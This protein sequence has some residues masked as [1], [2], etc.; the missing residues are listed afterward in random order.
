[1][2]HEFFTPWRETQQILIVAL[3]KGETM[4]ASETVNNCLTWLWDALCESLAVD[5]L[6]SLG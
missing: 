2:L 5:S 1:M 6:F 3:Y 4:P